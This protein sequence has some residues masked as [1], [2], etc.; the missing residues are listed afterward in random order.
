MSET[1]GN[2]SEVPFERIG[3]EAAVR[4]L[5]DCFYDHMDT[6]ADATELRAL[7]PASLDGSR[8]KLA[9]Y[10][11]G[12]MG[13]PQVY[14]QKFGHPRL[15]ARH[16]PFPIGVLERDQWMMCMR[17]ALAETVADAELRAFLDGNFDRLADHM[18]NQPG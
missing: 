13:G 15:R 9:W 12:W 8:D 5:V 10:L 2:R 18:R 14:V 1:S 7:H 4:R 6:L 16:L 17:R 3:G 11:T